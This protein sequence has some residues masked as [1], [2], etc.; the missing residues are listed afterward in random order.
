MAAYREESGGSVRLD[1]ER[2]LEAVWQHVDSLPFG[3]VRIGDRALREVEI[4]RGAKGC[5]VSPEV[6]SRSIATA[7]RTMHERERMTPAKLSRY[8]ELIVRP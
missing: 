3:V 7:R 5:L 6:R 8:S 1:T 4:E 2:W